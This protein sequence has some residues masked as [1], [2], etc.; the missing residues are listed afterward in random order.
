MTK[1]YT[2]EAVLIKPYLCL[3]KLQK[4]CKNYWP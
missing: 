2:V 3:R 4:T 1:V